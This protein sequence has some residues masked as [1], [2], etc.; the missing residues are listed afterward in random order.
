MG[1]NLGFLY[2]KKNYDNT[3]GK[4]INSMNYSQ[5]IT[6]VNISSFPSLKLTNNKLDT[7]SAITTYPGLLL[8]SGYTHYGKEGEK[9]DTEN[10]FKIGFFFDHTT[11]M[12]IIPGSS[13]KGVL[14]SVFPQFSKDD[15]KILNENTTDLPKAEKSL[16][17]AKWITTL[18]EKLTSPSFNKD[19]FFE[20][21]FVP[22]ETVTKEELKRVHKFEIELFDTARNVFYDSFPTEIVE[23]NI[24]NQKKL[25]GTDS[26]TPHI[27]EGKTYEEAMLKD[28]VPLKFL[29]V[30]PNVKFDFNFN[31]KN[32]TVIKTLN[33]DKLLLLFQKILL[34]IGI[35]AK[36]NV[37]YGQFTHL[38]PNITNTN[39][40]QQETKNDTPA[41]APRETGDLFTNIQMQSRKTI[42]DKKVFVGVCIEE[43][44]SNF[45]FEFKVKNVSNYVVKKKKKCPD[46][47]KLNDMVEIE[48]NNV[49]NNMDFNNP[50]FKVKLK[51]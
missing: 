11:G 18:I 13:L 19:K 29:K 8:G 7:F 40:E 9:T 3:T 39:T 12:P 51:H 37:G 48:F 26:I 23:N 30:L 35:G 31:L 10:A 14:R 34:T 15:L 27:K 2:Y 6:S 21:Y 43:D 44:N 24:G 33:K 42:I 32:S 50:P 41:Q 5:Q 1:N 49:S 20:D 45:Q 16:V 17:K 36:T 4:V 47:L 28:P 25:F 22:K 38:K 46:G